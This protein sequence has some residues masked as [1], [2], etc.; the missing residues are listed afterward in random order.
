VHKHSIPT[1]FWYHLGSEEHHTVFE[2]KAIGLILVAH[3][4]LTRNEVPFPASILTYNQAVIW[5]GKNPSAKSGHYLLLHFRNLICHLQD[6]RDVNKEDLMVKWIAGHMEV[7]GN[8]VAD[9]EVK[10]AA[11]GETHSSPKKKSPSSLCKPLPHSVPALKQAH[12]VRLKG[13]WKDEWS[14]SPHFPHTLSINSSLA[15]KV[16][17]KL[18]GGLP[19]CQ[20]GLYTQLR[21]GHAPLNKHLF[22]S[23]RSNTPNCLQC[24]DITPKTVHHLLFTCPRYDRERCSSQNLLEAHKVLLSCSNKVQTRVQCE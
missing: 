6:K 12:N 20:A 15:S 18:V 4:L 21:T 10:L 5:S 1:T 8:E 11:K 3:L 16:F 24:R 7:K 13:I 17:M 22:C 19:K 23:K 14:E 9:R 2:A